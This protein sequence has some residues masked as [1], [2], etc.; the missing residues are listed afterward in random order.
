MPVPEP[1]A[2]IGSACR[3]PG[4][5]DTPSKLWQLLKEPKDLRTK[6]SNHRRWHP[7]A[8][9]HDDPEHHGTANVQT[10]Y[11]LDEDPADFDNAFFNIQPS[12]C[13]A[14]D[15][16]QRMLMET[17]YDSL[18]SAGH[19]IEQLRGSSTA[20]IVG[21][22]CDDWSGILYRDCET[23][24][25]YSATGTSR[26][27]ISNRVSYFFDW[28]GPSMTIDTACS[29][30]LVAVHVAIQALR[31][32]ESMVAIA[33]GSNLLLSPG[34]YIAEANLHML[35]PTGRSMM[36]DKDVD[37]YARGEGV[38][39]IILK[40]LSA[41]IRDGDHIECVIR[42]TGV[43]QDGRSQGLTM[44][45]AAAQAALIRT[46][47]ARAG[48]DIEKPEDRPQFFHAHGT[49]TPAGDPQEAEAI[50]RAFYTNNASDILY[51]GSI[52]TVIG[53]TEGTAGLASLISTSLALQHS[54]IPPN[55][56][57]KELNPRISPFYGNLHVPT[58]ALPWPELLPGGVRRASVNSFGF[59]GTN[60]HAIVEAYE[61]P[62]AA[63]SVGQLFSP[64]TLSAATQKSLRDTLASYSDYLKKTKTSSLRDI[65]YTLQEKRSTLA[66]RA[67]V[68]ASTTVEAAQMIDMLLEGEDASGLGK[69]HFNIST[70]KILGVFT[71]QGAQWPR[72]GARLVEA[73]PFASGRL[74]ELDAALSSLPEQV[75][76]GWTL[77]QQL[78]A[79]SDASRISEA[80]V[81]QPLCTAVQIL[82][83]DMLNAAAIQLDAVVGHSSGE[84]AAAY[85]AGLLT[86]SNAIRIAYLRGFYVKL[87]KSP[88]GA[89]GAMM[90]AGTSLEDATEFCNLPEFEG[91]IQVAAVNSESSITLSG[92][93]DLVVDAVQTFTD[94]GK[95]ARLLKVDMAYHSAH[96]MPCSKPYLEAIQAAT[97]DNAGAAS[98]GPKPVWYSSVMPGQV[99]DTSTLDSQY[100]VSNMTRAV[101]FLSA[102]KAAV[103]SSGPFSLGLEIGPH[104]ALKSP[105]L[106]TLTEVQGESIPYSG[107]L[108]RGQD[109]IHQLST[110]LGFVWYNLGAGSVSFDGFEKK[111]SGDIAERQIVTD[112][113]K[114]VFDHSK[115]FWTVSR[116]AGAQLIDHNPPHPILGKRC[117]DRETSNEIQWR[118][119]LSPKEIPWLKGHKIQG[120][121][122]FPAAGFVAMAVEAMAL[123]APEASTISLI[124]ISN[125][126]IG[127]AISFDDETS[128]VESLF[129]INIIVRD[130]TI[131]QAKFCCY[132]GDPQEVHS[133]MEVN[134]EGMVTVTLSQPDPDTIPFAKPDFF[135]MSDIEVDR[136]YSQFERLEY[137]YS[138]PFRGMLSIGR[139]KGHAHG[140]IEDQSGSAW[141][142][143]LLIHPGMLD[144]A[145]QS[146]AAAFS[147]P[148]DGM[149][150]GLYIPAGIESITINPFF[151]SV[152]NTPAVREQ[153]RVLPWEAIARPMKGTRSF[154]DINILSQDNAHTFIQVEGLELMPFTAARPEAD[155][156]LFSKLEYCI[157]RPNGAIVAL[158]DGPRERALEDAIKGERVAFYYLRKLL[159]TVTDEEKEN[160]LPHYRHLLNWAS[161]VVKNV[162]DGRNSFVP[163]SWQT[164][165]AADI[166]QIYQHDRDRVDVRLIESVGN[167]LPQVIRDGTGIL[168]HMEGL[169]EFYDQGLGLDKA[170]RHL[171]RMAAQIGHRYPQMKIL[172]IGAGTGGS[173]RA[174]LPL[175]GSMFSSYTYTDIS[176]GFFEAAQSRF[177]VYE[178]RMIYK[179][180]DM[181]R[182]PAD[183]GFVDNSYDVIVASNVLHATDKLQQMLTN[184]RQL[185][186]PGGFLLCL[187]L[188]S[189]DSMRVGLPM[190]A[191][192]GWWVGAE[193]GR[194]WGPTVT[195]VH[196]DSL[197]RKCGFGGID[198]S[199]PLLHGLDVCTVF[200]AQAVDDRITLLR[201]PLA[202]VTALP[203]TDAPRLVI[204]GG[205][206]LSSHRIAENISEILGNR[207]DQVVRVPSLEQVDLDT[208]PYLSTVLSLTELDEPVFK[209][210]SE[211][212][213]EALKI[214]WRQSAKIL[215]ITQG[216]RA[217]EPFC[218]M[219]LG[220][221]RAIANEYP[222]ISLQIADL[223]GVDNEVVTSQL[224][225]S[226]LLR[227]ELL[228]T[229]RSET[230]D[231]ADFLWSLEPEVCFEGGARLIPRL[232]GCDAANRRYNSSRRTVT[233]NLRLDQDLVFAGN[234]VSYEL[235]KPSPLRI[236]AMSGRLDTTT[237]DVH[238]FL[239][240]TITVGSLGKMILCGGTDHATGKS[241]LALSLSTES[242][243]SVYKDWIAPIEMM[244]KNIAQS[245]RIVASHLIAIGLLKLATRGSAL[246]VHEPS[247]DI[248][249][250]LTQ[251]ARTYLVQVVITSSVKDDL[252]PGSLFIPANSSRRFIQK[253]V[254]TCDVS[255][256]VNL[257]TNT[258]GATAGELI[259]ESMPANCVSY[260]L[261]DL[262]GTVPSL[263]PATSVAQMAEIFMSACSA[264]AESGLES[265][266]VSTIR[267]QDLPGHAAAAFPLMV[268]DCSNNQEFVTANVQAIDSAVMFH[269]DKTYF[270]VGMSG[271]VGQSLCQWMV[272]HGARFIAMTSRS[273]NVDPRFLRSMNDL[274]AAVRVLS[275]DVT[276]RESLQKCYAEICKTMPPI[277]GVAQ[278]AMVLRDSMFDG[279]TYENMT[280]V[281][282]PKVTGTQLLDELFYDAPLD[283][284]IVMSSLTSVVGNS[285]QSN[286]IAANMFMVALAEQRRRR[287]VAGSSIAISS[288]IGIGYVERSSKF[289]ADY[290]EKLGY[291]NIAEPELH[292]LFAEA[293]LVGRPG[294]TESSEITTGLEPFYPQRN[295]NA[296]AQFF[297]DV[298]FNH[299]IR[300]RQDKRDSEG[301][302]PDVLMRVQLAEA[303]TED[304]AR[305][306][307]KDGFL[308][309]LCRTLMLSP[310]AALDEA[311]SLV[312]QGIDSLM[313]VEVRSWFLK[314]LDVDIPVLRILGGSSI[315]DLLAEAMERIP[316]A[317]IDLSVLSNAKADAG[318]PPRT[319]SNDSSSDSEEKVW[320]S[321]DDC[322][323]PASETP[324]TPADPAGA[325]TPA[326]S[327]RDKPSVSQAATEKTFAM[328]YGQDRFWFLSDYLEDKTSFNMTV[329]FKLTG[330]LQAHRLEN[331]VRAVAQRH[332]ALRTRFFWSGEEN[333]RTP[334]Q[335][336]LSESSIILEHVNLADEAEVKKELEKMHEYVWDLNSWEAARMVLIT[337]SDNFHYFMVSGH[338]ISW[339]GYSFSV[340]F[341]D[342]DAAYNG[343]PLPPLDPECQFPAF[344]TW[345]RESYESGSMKQSIENYYRPMIDPQAK[346][347]PL[348]PFAR[349]PTRPLLDHFEQ[350]EAKATLEPALVSKLKAVSRKN[351]AT[352]FH[353]YLAALQAL[354]FN[355]LPDVESFYL[356]LADANR[357]DKR[358]MDSLGF[359]L[360]LLPVR[361]DRSALGTKVSDMIKDTRNKTY[362]A[363]EHSAVPWNV[364]LH[365]LKIPRTNTEAPI[366]QLFVDYRQVAR[367]RSQ[368]CG[369]GLSDEEWLNARNGYDLTLGITDNPTGESLLSLRFQK[370]MYS[371]ESTEMFLRAFVNVLESFATGVNTDVNDLPR[372]AARDVETALEVGKGPSLQLEW[373]ETVSHRIDQ[374]IQLHKKKPALKDGLG[375]SYTYDQM[376]LRIHSITSKL[377]E[378][379]ITAGSNVGV[380]QTPSADWICSMLAIF[381][382]GATYVPMDL[383]NSMAR[384]MS[385]AK[386]AQPV[387]ILVDQST[388]PRVGQIGSQTATVIDVSELSK[389]VVHDVQSN[390]ATSSSQ[391][392]L[393][394][395]SGTTGEPKGVILTHEN[396]RSQCEGYSRMVSLPSMVTM[397]LQQTI[398]NFDISLDQIFSALTEG[399]CLYV[400]PAEK[401]GNPQAIT[402]IMAE[403][404]VTYTVATP[405]EYET[406]FRYGSDN[407]ARCTSWGYAFGGGEHLHTSLIKEFSQLAQWHVPGLRLFNNY[408][409][410]EASLAITK[411]EVKHS[412]KDLEPHVPAGW[413]IP[414]YAVAIVDDRL[415]PVPFETSGEVLAGGPGIAAGYL[416][417]DGLT[418]EKFI[419]GDAI[420]SLAA[421]T[422]DAWY[423]TGDRGRLRQDG[424]LYI[425]GRISG[426]TQVKIRGFRVELQEVEHVI[427]RVANG[428][429]SHA[430]VTTRGVGEDRALVA[431]VVFSPD[432]PRQNQQG[433]IHK[434]MTKLPLPA[435][436]QPSVIV[437][438]ASVPVTNNFKV[439][440]RAIDALPLPANEGV[441][442]N[443]AAMDKRIARL[444]QDIIPHGIGELTPE[445]NFFDVGGNSILLIKLKAAMQREFKAAPPLIDLMNSST[446]DGMSRHVAA[447]MAISQLEIDW[448]AESSVPESLRQLAEKYP[449]RISAKTSNIGVVLGGA[450]GYLGRHI[451]KSLISR[452]EIA[453]IFCLT[454]KTSID[455]ISSDSPKVKLIEADFALP[456]LGLGESEFAALAEATDVIVN[457]VANR[458]FWDGYS[459][460]KPVNVD[461]VKELAALS[462]CAGGAPLHTMS[463]G[464]V[465]AYGNGEPP[466]DGSDGYVASK[467]CVESFLA[468]ASEGLGINARIHR[469]VAVSGS[470]A[471][472]SVKSTIQSD[473]AQILRV[474][475]R[476]PDFTAVRGFIDVA[477][478][479]SVVEDI[480]KR[481]VAADGDKAS[482]FEH[483][484]ECRLY[485]QDFEAIV[486]GDAELEAL[487]V[488][489]P[490]PWFGETKR[491]GFAQLITAQELVMRNGDAEVV[492]AR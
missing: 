278:G 296:K 207:Y 117:K 85:A 470:I 17:V 462:I 253:A 153:Q 40:P 429:L 90:A 464:A 329:M 287:G 486:G 77:K 483:P 416:G 298:R 453:K 18:C 52:K 250:A 50:S 78:L 92:D 318:L 197:L 247:L 243:P 249:P 489:D 277:A 405:S 291:R 177:K 347:I 38:A 112:L 326:S 173:T 212:K 388:L 473:L 428:A 479:D 46:T 33:A 467:W 21:T 426:D 266:E 63:P 119:I 44:P 257:S 482:I 488:M 360:N 179:T 55:M 161:H 270:L 237:L 76:P 463:S 75:R 307:I 80:A 26:S 472:E 194:P 88:T 103:S 155:S 20:V 130:S 209:N 262:Y 8:F 297:E 304:E 84:I 314:E 148:G 108:S 172:E 222:H 67:A 151:A 201:W 195:P 417:R 440:R 135:N 407:L 244:G 59:G 66:F 224:L 180:F 61:M 276:K 375:V 414:N 242:R 282:E 193:N 104:P 72:M 383:R 221:G 218:S 147:C 174:I 431:H 352:M 168:E 299:F 223:D 364:L 373:P 158:D 202:A 217:N 229:W 365:E 480:A 241:I 362:K 68:A 6:V 392:V 134:A 93:A 268:V 305:V 288:L 374:I 319:V 171:A 101:M 3:F 184:V 198:T 487:P 86:A 114:Y 199:T 39:S 2:V 110:A 432:F 196:W 435:Y 200:A 391:A 446:L 295:A 53:H 23:I 246:V 152:P 206:S 430:V 248:I 445:T 14:I 98:K 12:E 265:A 423:R 419:P 271:Q 188:T 4:S 122:V 399:G 131:I 439:D 469:P 128:S 421:Q 394:F 143:Q 100:W 219:T 251:H 344:S 125:L 185:L 254:P 62:P 425:D 28:H 43:N 341:I 337:V 353:L 433:V 83:V 175:L 156:V 9:Y 81:S 342:L 181:E 111:L 367:E 19:T 437:T 127:R 401:R 183:Q 121:I 315:N 189:N 13:D 331:A 36:W 404:G 490:L 294:C 303:K 355:L 485:I 408:G 403:Q 308:A 292:Q 89:A 7:D 283:F 442:N 455:S 420:H 301:R 214:V 396:L 10:S 60:A 474:L 302:G 415:Q 260:G 370:K 438:L 178:D 213:L 372:F 459:T 91:R 252:Q 124:K 351:G 328:S 126:S 15:P 427:R 284:F 320:S 129:G 34:M 49:G 285:G 24:P 182:D 167:G 309:R 325:S 454:R 449:P 165:T 94:E 340:L 272:E 230:L 381:R 452:P 343:R 323:P 389:T 338:H 215:W 422:A 160:T 113:P 477:P 225:A 466:T 348:F 234:G 398:Y 451:L 261:G 31:N 57:F 146:S 162:K 120:G 436:M 118:N 87:A 157:D 273:P 133:P 354:V 476:R 413:V 216:A 324:T 192:P 281:L 138:P 361:F 290:F 79:G 336:I 139:K 102:V 456:C 411:G 97:N 406:W 339:D 32:G 379:G 35:S 461:A 312:E 145:L 245:L 263:N 220:L 48:L 51:V 116:A 227:L 382:M 468:K 378:S 170:N 492:S 109:D 310:D 441:M 465:K 335:G 169:F 434:L 259:R 448:E 240:H 322:S 144:T 478:V 137:Q 239:L 16:Q 235:Q 481:V 231:G 380:F 447:N 275:L 289:D 159:E 154:M 95:F 96:M 460:L 395:T 64:L 444:W 306:M 54:V 390:H 376:R 186:R 210:F 412:D 74:E 424:A 385:I 115:K 443:L 71:G 279:V 82:L 30:S 58:S 471:G 293:I 233:E 333:K 56:H 346:A 258:P 238:H 163:K 27:I 211:A 321:R 349:S 311:A 73:S 132:S 316:P 191:L 386:A 397:V 313:A 150:W 358:F 356:G 5:S 475:G 400:V 25:R 368:W 47:Y 141:E 105:S 267:V 269:A 22:M 457:C 107:V 149:M 330:R 410:T 42:E 140:T 280:G 176:S 45:S 190:G 458:S 286:Y 402:D 204:V 166:A 418:K 136:F 187:E 409:P 123:L 256:F 70:P 384:I 274:G 363:L 371:K 387:A 142:D 357:I 106:D 37:G 41:A 350:F 69:K 228:T 393:L 491:A 450:T 203:P 377:L 317:L 29:S 484:G 366:F 11:F 359:F 255:T 369:C 345:Q 208:L 332:D 300:E 232:Y 334:K 1:I 236:N 327:T 99:M 65:A 164:D 264:A 226:E 205:Q